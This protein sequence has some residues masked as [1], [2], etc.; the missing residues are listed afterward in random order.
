MSQS[1]RKRSGAEKE[2]KLTASYNSL[3]ISPSSSPGPA[4]PVLSPLLSPRSH[5]RRE[6][7]RGGAGPSDKDNVHHVVGSGIKPTE[8]KLP[9]ITKR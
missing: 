2:E 6:H 1:L 5:R 4:S 7:S 8:L 3:L 9:R